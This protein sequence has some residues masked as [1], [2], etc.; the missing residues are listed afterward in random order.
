MRADPLTRKKTRRGGRSDSEK[1]VWI[2]PGELA[3]LSSMARL[4]IDRGE[5]SHVQVA[6][7]GWA[8]TLLPSTIRSAHPD[9]L[10]D[11]AIAKQV[12]RAMNRAAAEM[13]QAE[14]VEIAEHLGWGKPLSG[15]LL[16]EPAKT[17]AAYAVALW[18][19]VVAGGDV[20][21]FFATVG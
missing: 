9:Y 16:R 18:R 21:T 11:I 8:V 12:Y 17:R 10:T 2:R 20:P 4:L 5:V 1:G 19:M 15:P 14:A 7:V 3:V 13:S 6:M